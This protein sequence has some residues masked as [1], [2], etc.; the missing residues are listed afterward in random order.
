MY[1]GASGIGHPCDAALAFSLRGFPDSD[2]EPRLQRIFNL[3]HVIEEIVEQDLKCI[4]QVLNCEVQPL[5]PLTGQQFSYQ[6]YGGHV[7]AHTDGQILFPDYVLVL[8]IKSMNNDKWK[9]FHRQG[10]RRS[11]RNYFDQVQMYMGLSGLRQTL[12]IAYNKDKSLYH[13]EVIDY[14][15]LEF[16]WLQE[17]IRR[18][19]AN[20]GREG[21]N[22]PVR[23]AVQGL[24]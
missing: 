3:G 6:Q 12:F 8:E 16:A 23:L 17:R 14:D 7:K 20:E 13:A 24:F 22:R 4:E 5:N 19:M 18:A 2:I 15:E 1:I 21:C 11:H 10:I 9:A